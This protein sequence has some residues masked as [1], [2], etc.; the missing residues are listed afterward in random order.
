MSS[1]LRQNKLLFETGVEKMGIS[2]YGNAGLVAPNEWKTGKL[3]RKRVH[4]PIFS[5]T[6]RKPNRRGQREK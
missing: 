1:C 4:I 3:I 2:V 5:I 6:F